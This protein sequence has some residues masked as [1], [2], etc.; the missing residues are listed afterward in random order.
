MKKPNI[1]IIDTPD[2]DFVL[3]DSMTSEEIAEAHELMIDALVEFKRRYSNELYNQ[4][5][6]KQVEQTL[7][8]A[9]VEL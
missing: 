9:G 7:K 1:E 8:K 6:H 4:D 2:I 3:V 5:F